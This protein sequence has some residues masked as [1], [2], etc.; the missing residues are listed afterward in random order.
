M[1]SF[2][3]NAL[4]YSEHG[5]PSEVLRLEHIG[6]PRMGPSDV[7]VEFLAVRIATM[8]QCPLHSWWSCDD[9]DP[10]RPS[11]HHF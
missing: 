6:L 10:S 5:P 7:L 2:A 8:V 11:L 1:R 4:R 3:T 9:H